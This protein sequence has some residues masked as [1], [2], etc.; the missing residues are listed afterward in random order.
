LSE[1]PTEYLE[2]ALGHLGLSEAMV[3]AVTAEIAR[4]SGEARVESETPFEHLKEH[5]SETLNK[6]AAKHGL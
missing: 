1:I 5:I 3:G 2:W 6:F 4:R